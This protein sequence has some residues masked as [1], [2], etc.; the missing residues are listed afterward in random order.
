MPDSPLPGAAGVMKRWLARALDPSRKRDY[1]LAALIGVAPSTVAF[2]AGNHA[3]I[4]HGD[5]VYQGFWE[6]PAWVTY[7]VFVPLALFLFRWGLS[8]I[9]PVSSPELPEERPGVV[10]L[11][12][13]D[14]GRRATYAALRDRILWPGNLIVTA[15]LVAVFTVIDLR[16]AA[17]V[18]LYGLTPDSAVQQ[19]W[20]VMFLTGQVDKWANAAQL[21]VAYAAQFVIL[22][23]PILFLVLM[24][25]HN[26]FFLQRVYQRRRV[27]P[28]EAENYV[29]V[30][31]EDPDFC[32]GF[33]RANAAFNVQVSCLYLA[34]LI[35]IFTR[36]SRVG[37]ASRAAVH[38][39]TGWFPGS[40]PWGGPGP[41]SAELV[42]DF[43]QWVTVLGWLGGLLIISA[44]GWVKLLPLIP[45]TGA[46]RS[47]ATIAGYLHEFL[48][49]SH[50]P[51][52]REPTRN[53]VDR[54][55]SK[56]AQNHFWPTGDNRAARLFSIAILA[57]LW[58]V[59][60]VWFG[61]Y[62]L[63]RIL[64]AFGLLIV[65]ALVITGLFFV[66][67]VY[68]IWGV[69]SRLV[70]GVPQAAL[71]EPAPPAQALADRPA[72]RL[73]DRYRIESE[74]GEGG[75]AT[76]YLA[77]DLKHNRNVALKVLKPDLAAA[78]GAERF[79]AEIT[80]TANLQHP[81]ILPLFDSGEADSS[82]FYVM[83]Y[84]EGESL[85][86]RIDR[87]HQLP[88]DEALRLATLV[89]GALDYAHRRGVIHRDIK[90]ANI[91]LHDGQP[92]V[93]DFGI[94][95]APRA[96]DQDR[97]TQTGMFV[98]TFK[99]MSPEQATGDGEIGPAS[100]IYSLGCVLYEMLCGEPPY[101]GSPM[102]VLTKMLTQSP[103]AI[104]E[105]RDTVPAHVEAALEKALAT[106]ASDRFG[107]A[108]EFAD[109][110]GAQ[111]GP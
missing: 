57:G 47:Q 71:M 53:E 93:A 85:R 66:F 84:L 111:A 109:A 3:S 98:G 105:I 64:G 101:T 30:D 41:A 67:L 81:H 106:H 12:R 23:I 91:L 103:K 28:A 20:A 68:W 51:F 43:G 49:D 86:E 25:Q 94:A 65:A 22:S 24:V 14:R 46:G 69:D 100:D 32:F 83:P 44:P 7:I 62:G 13:S 50:W 72:E 9:V 52:N 16:K 79:L 6:D 78:I 59:F 96:G 42:A 70:R 58:L 99:Y 90:P 110:L 18:Y 33:R 75:M 26:L 80:T 2:L 36:Q 56:F 27:P 87:D 88:V 8:R 38:L 63:G 73:E 95:L 82:V 21:G 60:P 48:P 40:A 4:P 39:L 19:D 55:A 34:G 104:R 10:E 31:L 92:V 5:L 35:L 102:A 74:L 108:G 37:D 107:T 15:V 17:S 11:V 29:V 77:R 61:D 54:L 89:A 97:L 45:F 76:V 1:A